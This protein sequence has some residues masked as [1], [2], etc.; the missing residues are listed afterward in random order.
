M[1]LNDYGKL[2][3]L[4]T[5]VVGAIVMMITHTVSETAGVGIIMAVVGYVTGNG[6]LATRGEQ[7]SQLLTS[8]RQKDAAVEQSMTDRAEG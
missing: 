7:P 5:A 2:I 4:T 8:Q 3:L 1:M 6:R